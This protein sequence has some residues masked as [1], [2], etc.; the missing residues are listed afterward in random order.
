LALLPGIYKGSKE[1]PRTQTEAYA[2][3]RFSRSLLIRL[4]PRESIRYPPRMRFRAK[5]GL[6]GWIWTLMACFYAYNSLF[7]SRPSIV[8]G[9]VICM[10]LMVL[11]QIL[12]RLFVYWDLDEVSL[13]VQ[14]FWTK[15]E[16]AW[17]EVTHVGGLVPD[18]P[19][20]AYLR[21]D[22]A[23]PAPMSEQ[24]HILANPEDRVKFIATLRRFAPQ[25]TFEV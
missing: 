7:R 20:S 8:G 10:F 24:G 11:L 22:Y 21:V 23:R 5:F 13:R 17:A 14:S 1:L 9:A 3:Q 4:N 15:K 6:L 18:K 25:A 2:L 19:S 12:S 16:I